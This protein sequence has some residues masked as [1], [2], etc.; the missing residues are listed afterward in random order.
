MCNLLAIRNL[1]D[2]DRYFVCSNNLSN[3]C[4]CNCVNVLR[5]GLRLG[6]ARLWYGW[7]ILRTESE[8]VELV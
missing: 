6:G 1:S 3:S 7:P 8:E 4:I 5:G 2:D